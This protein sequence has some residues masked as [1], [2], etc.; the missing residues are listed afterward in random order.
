MALDGASLI[1][2][3]SPTTPILILYSAE[4]EAAENVVK[5]VAQSK[6][7]RLLT[8]T[9]GKVSTE[10]DEVVIKDAVK[11]AAF[12]V[13]NHLAFVWFHVC[14]RAYQCELSH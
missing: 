13:Y 12:E 1:R 2:Q 14:A 10:E 8:L 6:D 7:V 9:L 4:S 3:S 5:D 11:I